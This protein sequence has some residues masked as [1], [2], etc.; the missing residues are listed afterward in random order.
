MQNEQLKAV[1]MTRRI[2][3]QMYEETQGLE[4]DELLRYIKERSETALRRVQERD[5][6]QVNEGSR[7]TLR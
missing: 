4:A 6:R 3:D 5:E 7:I 2:R 1:E